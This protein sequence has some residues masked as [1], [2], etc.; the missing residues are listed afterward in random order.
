[1]KL[2]DC[3]V[4]ELYIRGMSADVIFGRERITDEQAAALA[5]EFR[6]RRPGAER[7][8]YLSRDGWQ[9]LPDAVVA[10]I[11]EIV[12]AEAPAAPPAKKAPAKKA[13]KP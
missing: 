1:M 9:P 10:P 7:V 6:L 11:P 12:N 2:K 4:R 8:A 5:A 3:E 13:P